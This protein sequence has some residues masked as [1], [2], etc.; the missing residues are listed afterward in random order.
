MFIIA[1]FIE[2]FIT[3]SYL[4]G[5]VKI[6]LGVTVAAVVIAYLL[7]VGRDRLQCRRGA[8]ERLRL[9][10]YA[11]NDIRGAYYALAL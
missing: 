1:A 10:R 5:I 2:G 9:L 8:L 11:R 7:L 3:P 4:P 6:V